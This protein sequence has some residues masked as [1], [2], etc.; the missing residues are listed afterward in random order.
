M[1]AQVLTLS[2][3][4]KL[5]F[6]KIDAAFRAEMDRAVEDC[7]DRPLESKARKVSINFLLAPKIDKAAGLEG[8]NA[9]EVELQCEVTSTVPKRKTRVYTMRTQQNN[10]LLF[11]PDSPDEPDQPGMFKEED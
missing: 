2:T 1:D 6:G 9:D 10:G 7:K 4:P 3:L 5:D 11:Q 8:N